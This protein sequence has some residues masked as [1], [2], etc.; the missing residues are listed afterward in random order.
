MRESDLKAGG[1]YFYY[2]HI[3]K[4]SS[5]GSH[6]NNM[7]AISLAHNLPSFSKNTSWGWT[8]GPIREATQD[9]IVWLNECI[10]A[11]KLVTN[12]RPVDEAI[13]ENFKLY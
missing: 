13:I 3:I 11:G 12:P 1:Y 9:E 2:D 5:K 4:V 8:E 7:Q 6:S 10:L